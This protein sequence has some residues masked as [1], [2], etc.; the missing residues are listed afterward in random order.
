MFQI[1][2]EVSGI[3]N[4]EMVID[5]DDEIVFHEILV[6]GGGLAGLRSALEASE[7]VDTAVITKVHPLRSHSGAACYGS[8][9]IN[10][11]SKEYLGPVALALAYRFYLDPRDSRKDEI[12]AN[13]NNKPGI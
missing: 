9:P 5:I 12:I 11:K 7:Y 8:C 1:A 3:S 4:R 10:H 13:L 2:K 6:T